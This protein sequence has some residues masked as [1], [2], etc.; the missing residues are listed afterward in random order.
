M[1]GTRR[2]K[3]CEYLKKNI[4]FIGATQSIIKPIA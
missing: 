3:T 1:V 4:H 2:D